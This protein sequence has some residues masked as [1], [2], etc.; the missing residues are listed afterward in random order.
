MQTKTLKQKFTD[1]KDIIK[2]LESVVVAFSGGVDST[3]LLD[4]AVEVLGKENVLAVTS[5]AE[6]YPSEE[7]EDAKQF[8]KEIGAEHHITYT[9]ELENSNFTQNDK[10]RCYYCKKELFSDLKKIAEEKGYKYVLD[11]SNYDDK[12]ND[13]RPGLQAAK[14]LNIQSPLKEAEMT[15]DDIRTISKERGLPTWNKPSFACLSSRFPYGDEIDKDKLN[16]VE[17]GEAFL[18]SYDF[19]QLRLRHHDQ[20]TARIEILPEDMSKLLENRKEIVDELKKIGY[21]Y[22]T[23]DIEG[24]R[25]GSMNEVLE[26]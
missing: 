19:N 8:V 26:D 7:L 14:E 6:T 21:T 24:Y 2:E 15:K 18:R 23:L 10:N 12:V 13:Y 5:S 9:S 3:F 22:V 1:L 17:K 25:T 20:Y 4:I 16:M 11:G